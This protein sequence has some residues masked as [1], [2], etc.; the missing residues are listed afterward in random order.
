M[1]LT[2][3]RCTVKSVKATVM[4]NRIGRATALNSCYKA[5]DDDDNDNDESDDEELTIVGTSMIPFLLLS[6]VVLHAVLLVLGDSDVVQER[7]EHD[8]HRQH[9]EE[10]Q[11]F[12]NMST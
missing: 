7:P 1:H 8:R 6:V 11:D 12:D 4:T 9:E 3:T 2:Q 5:E 10:N